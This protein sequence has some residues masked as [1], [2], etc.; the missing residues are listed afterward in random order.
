MLPIW[1]FNTEYKGKKYTFAING[2]N[3]KITG[4]LPISIFKIF[5]AS[6]LTIIISQIIALLIR[7]FS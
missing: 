3:G 7:F 5:L 2:D 4:K 1:L 6:G